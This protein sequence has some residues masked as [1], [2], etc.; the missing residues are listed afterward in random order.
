MV[1]NNYK[2]AKKKH[3]NIFPISDVH[4]GNPQC[5]VDYFEY[6][7]EKI[8]KTKGQKIIYLLG[9][10]CD[11]AVKRQGN[12]VYEQKI[13]LNDQIEF[14]VDKLTPFKKYIRGIVQSNHMSRTKKE[15]DLDI[16]KIIANELE[17]PYNNNI[18][19]KLQINNNN[20]KIYV[21]HGT[22]TS[23]QLHLMM[24]N[25]QRQTEHIDGDLFLFG[26]SHY[27]SGWSQPKI[28]LNGYRRRYYV[29]CGHMLNYKGSYAEV[30]GLRPNPPGFTKICIDS[31]INTKV[32]IYNFDEEVKC[33]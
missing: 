15:L 10:E 11:V 2:V 26:H 9:D 7:L 8:K 22:K 19:E 17:I 23:Q 6:L 18:Y 25:I 16:T 28:D 3:L 24:G 32:N 21:T 4:Y 20:Y 5:N 29:I 30:M 33:K 31:K 14:I 1:K 13:N 27:T 12:S